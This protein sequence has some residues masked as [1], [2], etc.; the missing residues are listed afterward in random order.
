RLE[1][2]RRLVRAAR[3]LP[4]RRGRGGRPAPAHQPADDEYGREGDGDRAR[5][6]SDDHAGGVARRGRGRRGGDAP[7]SRG[8]RTRLPGDDGGRLGDA[9]G[10]PPLVHRAH[11][12][13]GDVR[14]RLAERVVVGV[15][16]VTGGQRADQPAGLRRTLQRLQLDVDHVVGEPAAVREALQVT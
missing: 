15:D 1:L 11:V 7:L 3:I 6:G 4:R 14:E 2:D 16:A 10:P 8:G 5:G 9:V 12:G 13:Q